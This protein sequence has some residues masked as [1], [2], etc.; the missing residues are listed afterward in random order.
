MSM[1]PKNQLKRV[2][3]NPNNEESSSG[4]KKGSSGSKRGKITAMAVKKCGELAKKGAN[5]VVEA[6]KDHKDKGK[7]KPCDD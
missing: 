6:Y 4:E 5:T 7:V 2:K 3:M 1:N